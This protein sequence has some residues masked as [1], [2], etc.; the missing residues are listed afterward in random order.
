MATVSLA[1]LCEVLPPVDAYMLSDTHCL[2]L[3]SDA[4]DPGLPERHSALVGVNRM[5]LEGSVLAEFPGASAFTLW[6]QG[7]GSDVRALVT[8]PGGHLWE[9]RR[10]ESVKVARDAFPEDGPEI[11]G[12]LNCCAKQGEMVYVGGMSQQLYRCHFGQSIF[13]RVDEG[14]LD[15]EMSDASSAI[16]ALADLD[17]QHMVGVGGSGLAFWRNEKAVHRIDSGTNAMLN[18]A[19]AIDGQTFLACG[20]GGVV[21]RGSIQGHC[22]LEIGDADVY[23]S[24]VRTQGRHHLWIGDQRLYESATGSAWSDLV[25]VDG[26]PAVSRFA[27]GGKASTWA[28]GP[29]SLGWT[30]NGE[31]WSWL[32]SASVSITIANA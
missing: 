22:Q 23:F 30:S 28:I 26:A 7:E 29:K 5:T 32:S 21:L 25:R 8:S 18:A 3:L 15:K 12:F 6:C 11:Y 9:H 27:R 16:Y 2:L 17:G 1:R 13:E 31:G 24:D 14:L 4:A 10:G 19:C 20:V